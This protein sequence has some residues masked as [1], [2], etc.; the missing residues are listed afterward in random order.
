MSKHD[1]NY[2]LFKNLLDLVMLLQGSH[3]GVTITDITQRYGV[4]RRTAERMRN[5]VAEFFSADFQ[6]FKDG[7]NKTFKLRTKYIDRLIVASIKNEELVSIGLG[8]KLLRKNGMSEQAR[9]LE[10]VGDKIRGLLNL[11]LAKSTNLEDV[12]KFEGHGL[13]PAPYLKT[14]PLVIQRIREA[15]MSFHAIKIDYRNREGQEREF[16]LV[17]LGILYGERNH[18]LVAKFFEND[19]DKPYHFIL[20]L[21]YKVEVLPEVFE[22]DRDFSLESHAAKSFGVFQEEPVEVEWLFS[23]QVAREAA[24]F[25]FHPSQETFSNNDGSLTVKFKAGGLLEMAWHLYTGGSS[26]KVIKPVDFWENLP[27]DWSR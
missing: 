21:I 17:P 5:A 4:A 24:N 15:M 3:S 16:N 23:P 13:R 27:E 20:D 7:K 22:E 8:A 9:L 18:Y 19:D 11:S 10:S 26:V 14:D 6:E 2:G 1:G 25:V 12:M